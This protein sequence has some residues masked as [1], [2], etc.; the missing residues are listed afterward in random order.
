MS[1]CLHESQE[2]NSINV[3]NTLRR[4]PL[5]QDW[6]PTMA[7]VICRLQLANEQMLN[8]QT[9]NDPLSI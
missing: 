5:S 1:S 9:A 3:F 2:W 4:R 7:T 8:D 6:L